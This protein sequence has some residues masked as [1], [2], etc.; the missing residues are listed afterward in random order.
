ME[1]WSVPRETLSP[2]PIAI[3]RHWSSTFLS[4]EALSDVRTYLHADKSF[5]TE[6]TPRAGVEGPKAHSHG[7][8][9]A[10]I[11]DETMGSACWYNGLPVLAA[12]LTV[13][14]RKSVPLDGQYTCEA[15]IDRLETRRAM[16]SAR[17]YR[18]ETVY[19]EATGVFVRVPIELLQQ[20]PDMARMVE[21]VTS[22]KAGRTMAELIELDKTNRRSW[23]H[24]SEDGWEGLT[25]RGKKLVTDGIRLAEDSF[26]AILA[27]A[28]R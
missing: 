3:P 7:G 2:G 6:F 13:R 18:G 1:Q 8:F 19:C 5:T 9:L 17:I 21:I 22:L 28:G 25:S 11:L 14:Y 27:A 15:K 16:V 10:T 26:R 20:Q 4:N 23:S 24:K 12:N